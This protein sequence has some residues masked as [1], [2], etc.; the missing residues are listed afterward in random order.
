MAVEDVL[1]RL[2][3]LSGSIEIGPDAFTAWASVAIELDSAGS[4]F[5][6]G[7]TWDRAALS[8]WGSP[9]EFATALGAAAQSYLRVVVGSDRCSIEGLAALTRLARLFGSASHLVD[10][11][12]L[13]PTTRAVV[14][15]EIA[16]RVLTCPDLVE[17]RREQL[18]RGLRLTTDLV[19]RFELTVPKW[20]VDWGAESG[21][22]G[23]LHFSIP[24]PFQL[25]IAAG[26]YQGADR[27][28]AACPEAITTPGLIGWR[29]A[30][31]GFLDRAAAV[32]HFSAAAAA[33]SRD[34]VPTEM[35]PE[36]GGWSSINVDLWAPYFRAR[37]EL[38]LAIRGPANA[39]EHVER[40]S[41]E[42]PLGRGG[43][44]VPE[45]QR[46]RALVACLSQ[47]T[48]TG[49]AVAVEAVRREFELATR[50]GESTEYDELAKQFIDL[51]SAS[52]AGFAENPGLEITQGHLSEALTIL[53]RLPVLPAGIAEAVRPAAGARATEAVLGPKTWVYAALEAITDERL[54]H[55]LLLRLARVAVPAYAQVLHGPLEH[56]KDVAVFV[57]LDTG[58][59]LR[60]YQVK[61]GELTMKLWRD[62]KQELEAMFE[63]PVS[64]LLTGSEPPDHIV[65]Y[66]V[67]NSHPS[68]Y[69]L[70]EIEGWLVLQRDKL[71]RDVR[72]MHIDALV[73]Y[74]YENHLLNEFRSFLRDEGLEQGAEGAP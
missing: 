44:A 47:L 30:V 71:G 73:N 60:L 17:G 70:P 18:V 63:V 55:R 24:S 14:L 72:L 31:D 29:H 59:E 12:D 9:A 13:I 50:W 6:A 4:H 36:R 1:G 46:F 41:A 58:T 34:V 32:E 40:A 68:Q 52:L 45:V 21:G 57:R 56:G 20:E 66:L 2:W 22:A 42:L 10:G 38:A 26:D 33:F 49:P 65:G 43:W 69:V 27:T 3:A 19:G 61:V 8:A 28:A 53:D 48:S 16:T 15:D 5:A 64:S 67:V 11:A 23:L 25:F 37:S 35:D 39:R 7:Y 54:L 74:I 51:A 62:A